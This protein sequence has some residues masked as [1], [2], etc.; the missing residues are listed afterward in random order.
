[1][2]AERPL[3]LRL[4]AIAPLLGAQADALAELCRRAVR[5]DRNT[6][7]VEQGEPFQR[8]GVLVDGWAVKL[9]YLADGRRQIVDF[10][11][12]GSLIAPESALFECADCSV[13]TLEEATLG[14][15]TRDAWAELLLDSPR[16]LT[17]V[18]WLQQCDDAIAAERLASLG[19]R[20]ARERIAHLLL[21]L[22][23]RGR[24]VGLFPGSYLDMPVTQS[25]LGDALGLSTVHVNRSMQSLRRDGLIEQE[26]GGVLLRDPA[27]LRWVAAFED[28]YLQPRLPPGPLWDAPARPAFAAADDSDTAA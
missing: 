25:M 3:Q 1:M 10:L 5:V 24:A 4:A 17:A 9:R 20:S 16:L 7:L 6:A 22:R 13:L 27:G 2:T 15:L 26:R 19:Q 28:D 18:Q 8:A 23:T 11:L 14:T 21:E 12:P